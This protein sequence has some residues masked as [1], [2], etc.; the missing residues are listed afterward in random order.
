[1]LEALKRRIAQLGANFD[2]AILEETR[3]LY[4]PLLA[5]PSGRVKAQYDVPYL[6]DRR[7]CL[8]VFAPLEASNRPVVI[9]V[10][11]GGFVAC[12]KRNEHGF[13]ANLG[14]YF[15][16]RGFVV[17]VMNYRVAPDHPWPAGG[18]D[19]GHAV[20]WARRHA[21]AYGGN[22][23]R[24]AIFGQSAGASHVATWLFDPV[25]HGDKPVS[26]VVLSSG[27]YRV[28][29]NNV[30]ANVAAYFG[31]DPSQYEA[32]S[33]ITHVRATDIPVLLTVSEFDPPRL[34]APTFDFASKLT[35]ING[36]PS[37]LVWLAGHNHVS[38]V[39]SIGTPDDEAARLI[40]E[41]LR[42]SLD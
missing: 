8:D 30:P 18:E 9:F 38:N 4:Q 27:T 14:F 13:Y 34:A 37:Q 16:E 29:G 5:K 11:G 17:L 7:Q 22:P 33:P 39:L 6:S 36:R 24:I 21:A 12:E 10:P 40:A 28:A 15:A 19:V 25:L 31:S 26:A 1:M 35:T 42:K 32:R 20:N 23:E 2:P 41:F 3:R